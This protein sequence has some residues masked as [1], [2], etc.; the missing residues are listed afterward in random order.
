VFSFVILPNMLPYTVDF[1]RVKKHAAI[2]RPGPRCDNLYV[3]GISPEVNRS[4]NKEGSWL[5]HSQNNVCGL[6][7]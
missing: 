6:D 2:Y 3:M 4:G 1:G 5:V 7:M